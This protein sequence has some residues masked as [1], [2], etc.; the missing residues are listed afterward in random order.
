MLDLTNKTLT[1]KKGSRGRIEVEKGPTRL[2]LPQPVLR[3]MAEEFA[4]KVRDGVNSAL[5]RDRLGIAMLMDYTDDSCAI[6]MT[7]TDTEYDRLYLG[8]ED[9]CDVDATIDMLLNNRE[10][11]GETDES[12][13]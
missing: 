10:H 5:G 4:E 6:L 3:K 9:G 1:T 13:Q 11:N 8:W 7:D 12:I 2:V